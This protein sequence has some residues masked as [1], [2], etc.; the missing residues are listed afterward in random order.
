MLAERARFA[1]STS[2]NGRRSLDDSGRRLAQARKREDV[3]AAGLVAVAGAGLVSLAAL[4][5]ARADDRFVDALPGRALL[6]PT[7]TT[8]TP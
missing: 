6:I 7:T 1:S 4:T 3:V 5:D 2:S 8:T